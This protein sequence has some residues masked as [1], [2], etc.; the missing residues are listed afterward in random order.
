MND[1]LH[2]EIIREK[3]LLHITSKE[4]P[5]S[6][7]IEI[8]SF[9]KTR[10]L[11]S[12]IRAVIHVTCAKVRKVLSSDIKDTMLKRS[13]DRGKTLIWK[14]SSERKYS[15]SY[16]LRVTKDWRDKPQI[17]KRVRIPVGIFSE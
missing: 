5:Y 10:K 9:A 17:L 14:I 4:I 16:M 15:S 3:I 1:F 2:A 13:R 7:E 8:E 6:V 12:R 11:L